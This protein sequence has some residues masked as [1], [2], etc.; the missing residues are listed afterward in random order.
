METLPIISVVYLLKTWRVFG[1]REII[2]CYVLICYAAHACA[3]IM[4][5]LFNVGKR[6]VTCSLI[7]RYIVRFEGGEPENH[8]E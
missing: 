3:Q 7:L 1:K 2:V 8:F 5:L 4:S 6:R